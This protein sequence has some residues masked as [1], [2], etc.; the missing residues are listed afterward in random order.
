V[1]LPRWPVFTLWMFF[2]L[3]TAELNFSCTDFFFTIE[4]SFDGVLPENSLFS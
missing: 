1:I 4:F 2:I 3:L